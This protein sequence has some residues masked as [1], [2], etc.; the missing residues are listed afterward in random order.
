MQDLLRIEREALLA[1]DSA[2][3]AQDVLKIRS[4][5]LG[6][7]G[8]LGVVLRGLG[9]LSA[10]ERPAVGEQ[11]NAVKVRIETALQQA[12]ERIAGMARQGELQQGRYDVTLPGRRVVPG[13]PHPLRL[14]E[15]EIIECLRDLGFTVAEGPL[16]EH[17]WYNFEALHIPAEHPARDMQDTFFVAPGVVLRT[18]TS[19]VQIRTMV[20]RQPPVRIIAPG[21]VFRHDEVDATHSP[22]FHQVE[23]LWVDN[24]ATFAD[25]KGVL[26]KLVQAL[27]GPNVEL[28]FRPSFFPFTEPSVEIDV[29]RGEGWLEIL[30]AG[31]V[32]PAVLRA[33][34]YDP[35]EVQGFAFGVGVE[36][37][38]LLRWGIDDIRLFYENDL[39]FVR[40]FHGVSGG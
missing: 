25:L 40:Q 9:A 22:V 28:R 2:Q 39:R 36:R 23:G 15:E 6:K 38:A 20:K 3:T 29:R 17:D 11:V 33:V 13:A 10:E 18:H 27:F 4:D 26:R 32:D 8:H 7:K 1:A 31:M 19:N 16:V 12:Q 30:G 34:G 21:M 24:K 14:I 37:I 35:E 5:F